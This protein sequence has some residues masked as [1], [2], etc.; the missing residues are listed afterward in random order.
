[1]FG[2]RHCSEGREETRIEEV[3]GHN[4]GKCKKINTAPKIKERTEAK[5]A[6]GLL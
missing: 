6:W 3:Y 1:M 5:E 2:S 4:W